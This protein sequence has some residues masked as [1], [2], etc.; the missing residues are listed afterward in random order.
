MSPLLIFCASG[1]E[2][3]A[4]IALYHNFSYGA[5]LPH[6]V[7]VDP[8][9]VDQ[10]W[11]RPQRTQYMRALAK[12]RPARATVLDLEHEEQLDEVLDWADEASQFVVKEVIIIPKVMGIIER[13]PRT[14][15]GKPIVLGYSVPTRYS[16]TSLP[17]WQFYGWPVHLLGGSPQRQVELSHYLDVVS[18][19]GNYH[20]KMATKYNQF[21]AAGGTMRHAANRW[22]PQLQ[23]SVY[24]YV[25]H[26]APYFAF[27]L[28]CMNIQA[29]WQG[30]NA[31]IRFAVHDDIGSIKRIGYM[32]REELGFVHRKAIAEAI[33]RREVY[34]AVYQ[35]RI[36][37]FLHWHR[38]RDG[39]STVY[40]VAVD[41]AHRRQRVGAGLLASIP[42]PYRLKCTVDN[43]ANQFYEKLGL[44]WKGVEQGRKR[45]LNIWSTTSDMSMTTGTS[46]VACNR[47]I[48]PE[49]T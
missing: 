44:Y 15:R 2:R 28:S 35:N 12:Y 37:G 39:W 42:K 3:F 41:K 13:L 36:V 33:E 19:D 18:T 49:A 43:P 1:N 27:E 30:C 29:Y 32:Y 48:L 23:E 11:E 9:F 14:V 5:Q 10:Q 26:D 47:R 40:E 25:K 8:V 38:R 45:E 17:V 22:W 16:A 31:T 46:P 7:H 20:L 24:G 21:F 34:V 6:T 4:Q